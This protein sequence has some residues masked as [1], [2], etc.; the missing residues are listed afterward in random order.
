MVGQCGDKTRRVFGSWLIKIINWTKLAHIP[1]SNVFNPQITLETVGEIK[2]AL[3]M[4]SPT[5]E[6]GGWKAAT[7]VINRKRKEA[8]PLLSLPEDIVI[9][10]LMGMEGEYAPSTYIAAKTKIKEIA[11]IYYQTAK[12]DYLYNQVH[13]EVVRLL[14][15]ADEKAGQFGRGCLKKLFATRANARLEL[16][17]KVRE[18]AVLMYMSNIEE[19]KKFLG[20]DDQGNFELPTGNTYESFAASMLQNAYGDPT[21]LLKSKE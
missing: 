19:L 1:S 11:D 7:E 21:D 17:E 9:T 4:R 15:S 13:S 2:A 16:G 18:Q 10:L 14:K 20:R 5:G 12:P 3:D 6:L 8:L